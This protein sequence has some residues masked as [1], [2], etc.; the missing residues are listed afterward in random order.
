MDPAERDAVGWA[1]GIRDGELSGEELLA[2]CAA[3]A[4]RD[5]RLNA[6]VTSLWDHP[7]RGPFRQGPL[8][9]VPCLVK[10]LGVTLAGVCHTGGSRLGVGVVGDADSPYARHLLDAGLVIAGVT[11]TPE[12][13]GSYG[14]DCS[15]FGPTR[16]PWDTDRSAGGSSSGS[17]AAVAVGIVP[18][19]HGNDAGGSLRAPASCCGLFALKPSRGRTPREHPAGTVLG[20]WQSEHVLTR[21][22]RDSAAVLAG[23]G[24]VLDVERDLRPL[25]IALTLEGPEGTL[26]EGECRAAAARTAAVLEAQGHWVDVVPAPRTDPTAAAAMSGLWSDA[27]A[28]MVHGM[29]ARAGR[30]AGP[31]DLEPRTWA[32]VRESAARDAERRAADHAA[33]IQFVREIDEFFSLWDVWLTPTLSEPP[34]LLDDGSEEVDPATQIDRDERYAMYLPLANISGGPA[35]SLPVAK[36]ESGLPIGVHVMGRRGEDELLLRLASTLERAGEWTAGPARVG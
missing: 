11:N 17:A 31:T 26:V 14:S 8:A 3:A 4:V 24:P 1:A 28:A 30:D 7:R 9:G 29:E 12:F 35:A 27:V 5:T 22:V 15:L 10:D 25:R 2:A 23:S 32:L 18:I 21:S 13:G 33:L 19:A 36:S 6:I 34:P 16:N 20:D